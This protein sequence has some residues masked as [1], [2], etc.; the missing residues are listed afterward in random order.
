VSK[1]SR[2]VVVGSG[3]V[4]SLLALMLKKRG[5]EV[6]LLE[7]RTDPRAAGY[8]GGRSINLALSDRGLL[9][10]RAAGIADAVAAVSVAMPSRLIHDK[11]SQVSRFAYGLHG[12]AIHSVSRG[13]LN[14][15]LLDLLDEHGVDVKF[16]WRCSDVALD[17]PRVHALDAAGAAHVVDADV[18][19]GCDGAF[20]QVRQAMRKTDRFD[21]EQT[22]LAH[23][24]KELHI[25]TAPSWDVDGL[26]IW[27]RQSHMLIALPNLDR[28]FT[29]TLFFPFEGTPSF[30]SLH[31]V[32]AARRYFEETFPDALAHVPDFD[33]QW[34][35]NPVS[36]LVTVRC[37]PWSRF[38]KTMIL[39]DAAHAIVPF[40]GQGMNCGFEDCRVLVELLDAHDDDWSRA[41]PAFE[42]ARKENADAIATFALE[43]FVEMRDKIADPAFQLRRRVEAA[44]ARVCEK[45]F[46]P[47]YTMVTFRPQLP[48]ADALRQA[49]KQDAILDELLKH[50]AVRRNPQSDDHNDLYRKTV[51]AAA[52]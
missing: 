52:C 12:E 31:D 38:G 29:C 7:R 26:H 8:V 1:T 41:M 3:L 13:G 43:N 37:Y 35:N 11:Q 30:A 44:V 28:S 34:K 16:G 45:D 27:P 2:V 49:R 6:T 50:E 36:S 47:S 32:A 23:G 46:T 42:R 48:Y 51:A 19:I 33:A 9:A 14:I 24:Y 10:L 39:G 17:V 40:F 15:R 18:V 22:F 25:Q 21:D 20:S 5:A 4:G